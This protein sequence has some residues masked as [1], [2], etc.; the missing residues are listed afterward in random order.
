M[1]FPGVRARKTR[2]VVGFDIACKWKINY[3]EV[4]V[5]DPWPIVTDLS[6]LPVAISAYKQ[7]MGIEEMF[8]DCKTGGSSLEGSR[9]RVERL[10]KIILLIWRSFTLARYFKELKFRKNRCKN[11]YLAI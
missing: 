4:K 1:Y 9:L 6:S 11:I 10:I 5:K 8:R 7:R 2:A 3:Q